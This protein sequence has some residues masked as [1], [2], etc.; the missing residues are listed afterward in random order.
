MGGNG[1]TTAFGLNQT[2]EISHPVLQSHS[3]LIRLFPG[4]SE[5]FAKLAMR[6]NRPIDQVRESLG[7]EA[8]W[9]IETVTEFLLV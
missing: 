9:V 4:V 6:G 1:S 5:P 3:I 7:R 8:E 2:V